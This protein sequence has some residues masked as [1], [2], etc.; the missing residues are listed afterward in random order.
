MAR[1]SQALGLLLALLTVAAVVLGLSVRGAPLTRYDYAEPH[2]GT[3]FR[4]VLYAPNQATA[5]QAAHAAF[6]RIEALNH[7]MSDYLP[8]SELRRLSEASGGGPVK[9]SE[10][11]F[12]VLAASQEIARRSGGAFDITVGPVVQLW[13][14]ARRQR[15][16]PDH[17]SL[18]KAREKVGY[19]NLIL[20]PKARTARLLKPG[21]ELDLGAIG[22]GYAA[23]EA[24]EVLAHFGIHRALVA[25]GGD[26]AVADPPPAKMGWLVAIEPLDPSGK[27]P[28]RFVLLRRAAISTSGDSEQHAEIGGVRYSHVVDPRTGFA[29]TGR[30]SVTVVARRGILSDGLA[31]AASV[32][33]PEK[34]LKLIEKTP[35]A[36]L[37][38]VEQAPSGIGTRKFRFPPFVSVQPS[39]PTGRA[40][41]SSTQGLG[42]RE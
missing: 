1:A 40:T 36:G 19:R 32:L 22:K 13:R 33:G 30:R 8:T 23:D 41:T 26:I 31:T 25:G 38:Y 2:M 37:F 21:M 17:D 15:E 35:G 14:R 4:I 29:L 6:D 9:V 24:L 34:G 3:M 12:R 7:I 10:D 20:D 5:D 39:N 18:A 28:A 42:T 27:A 11:L 16:L